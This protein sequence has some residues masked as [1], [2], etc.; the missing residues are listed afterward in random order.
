MTF[1]EFCY[2]IL[3]G[4]YDPAFPDE[5][6]CTGYFQLKKMVVEKIA[7][8]SRREIERWETKPTKEELMRAPDIKYLR[9]IHPIFRGFVVDNWLDIVALKID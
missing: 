9:F 6:Q 1:N 8:A 3:D 5:A 4:L 7:P 2:T